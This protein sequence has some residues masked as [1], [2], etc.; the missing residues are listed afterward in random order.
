MFSCVLGRDNAFPSY[1]QTLAIKNRS[2]ISL[3]K[4]LQQKI[5]KSQCV[6]ADLFAPVVSLVYMK[7]TFIIIL[8]DNG[9][10]THNDLSV[11]QTSYKV[12]MKY[13]ECIQCDK[14][15]DTERLYM[16]F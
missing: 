13:Y 7:W 6:S 9:K 3:K 10:Q 5:E 15:Y 14:H 1:I 16:V 4:Q 8:N 12:S 11:Y 2:K